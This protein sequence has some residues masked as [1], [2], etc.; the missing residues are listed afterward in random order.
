MKKILIL[1]IP[2]LFS[3]Q[4]FAQIGFNGRPRPSTISS[5]EIALTIDSSGNKIPTAAAAYETAKVAATNAANL[6]KL[7]LQQLLTTTQKQVALQAAQITNQG[8]L[9]STQ[10]TTLT[11]QNA[12]L[13]RYKAR[14]DSLGI[15]PATLTANPVMNAWIDSKIGGTY[16]AQTA[17]SFPTI[18]A[19]SIQSVLA[20]VSGATSY[21]LWKSTTSATDGF[22][23]LATLTPSN[24]VYNDTGLSPSTNYWYRATATDGSKVSTPF[25]TSA[26]TLAVPNATYTN[27]F[28]VDFNTG[29]LT[30]TDSG[31]SYYV[32]ANG[33][34]AVSI[35]NGLLQVPGAEVFMGLNNL[36]LNYP[37][38]I[39]I[40]GAVATSQIYD[41]HVSSYL[42]P[43][44]YSNGIATYDFDWTGVGSA[45]GLYFKPNTNTVSKINFSK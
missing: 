15:D 32:Q 43:T 17:I 40:Y 41:W 38:H 18:T 24:L 30:G 8:N 28:T 13:A 23:F 36:Y 39:T 2:V 7:L 1:I 14:M 10:Q 25:T 44:S 31:V 22:N 20:T 11:N 16:F 19:T 29:N 37:V 4:V 45:N 27:L 33:G 12:L 21:Q 34:S 42:N 6:V 9:I 3:V 35:S 5:A 26:T